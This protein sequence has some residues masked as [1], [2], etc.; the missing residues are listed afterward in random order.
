MATQ[1]LFLDEWAD[2]IGDSPNVGLGLVKNASIDADSGALM[3]NY[4]PALVSF[5][6]GQSRTFTW[7]LAGTI[8]L[9]S[10]NT[11]LETDGVAVT[12]STAGGGT[13]DSS[14]V[15][16][17]IYFL[18]KFASG[19][20]R[21]ASTLGNALSHLPMALTGDGSGTC[22]V[23]TVDIGTVN[24]TAADIGGVQYFL[25]SNGRVWFSNTVGGTAY[26]LLGNTLTQ[27]SG[28]GLATFTNS[29]GSKNFLFVYRNSQV[30]VCDVTTQVKRYDPIGTSSWTNSWKSMSSA[31]GYGGSHQALVGYDN[32]LYSC[33]GRY[34]DAMQE[35]PGKVFSPSDSTTYIWNPTALTLPQNDIAS[36]IEQLGVNLLVGGASTQF[37]Y[38][39]DRTSPSFDLP[40]LCPE[41]SVYGMKNIGNRVWILNGNRGIVYSTTGYS[42]DPV[43]KIPE[44]LLQGSVGVSNVITWGGV[45]SKNGA[46]MFGFTSQSGN[47]GIMMVYPDGRLVWENTPSQGMQRV[48]CFSASSGEFYY[49]GYAG[50][51]DYISGQRYQSLGQSIAWSRLYNVGNHFE[52]TTFSILEVQ[53]DQPGV[54]GGQVRVSYRGSSS[55]AFTTLATYT[56][57]GTTTSFDSDIGL[58][59][60]EN[61][62]IQVE[63]SEGTNGP[64]GSSATR[65]RAVRLW[66]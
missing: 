2:G 55:G 39:W 57:D 12:F 14:I 58:I 4:Q 3:A 7:N 49:S 33:D 48:K 37:I 45:A 15:A 60:I 22:T 66:P 11:T 24:C 16:G 5:L 27:A 38:P 52:K 21:I 42:V 30:D 47:G 61:I 43:R 56:L 31:N 28:M 17:T 6:P 1:P 32:I 44:T 34:I 54:A 25:D 40:L 53:L 63:V 51:V 50:G 26:L 59:D 8:D 41:V 35:V 46:F 20:C 62:Q 18:F 23:Q 9:S 65:V 64:S 19:R 13:L 10:P 36:C 29:D